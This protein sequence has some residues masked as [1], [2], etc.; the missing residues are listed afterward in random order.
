MPRSREWG[1]VLEGFLRKM[2]CVSALYHL[3]YQ[4]PTLVTSETFLFT[5][6]DLK[7]LGLLHS[8]F[9]LSFALNNYD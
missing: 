9:I 8:Q 6:G 5:E 1:R 7:G 4:Q 2:R 3:A